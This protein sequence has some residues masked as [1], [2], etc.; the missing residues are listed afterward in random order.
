[1]TWLLA[2]AQEEQPGAVNRELLAF[3]DG[4]AG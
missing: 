1:M 4:W 3:L 2:S